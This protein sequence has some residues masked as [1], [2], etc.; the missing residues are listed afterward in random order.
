M[1]TNFDPSSVDSGVLYES[2]QKLT[3]RLKLET[4]F[5]LNF[6][7]ELLHY[8]LPSFKSLESQSSFLTKDHT[9]ITILIRKCGSRLPLPYSQGDR[10]K[11]QTQTHILTFHASFLTKIKNTVEVVGPQ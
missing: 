3:S 5:F 1:L 2:L 8:E 4:Q 9:H 11:I 10:N 6:K 7:R